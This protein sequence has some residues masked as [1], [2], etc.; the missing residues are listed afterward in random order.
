MWFFV[1]SIV[2]YEH[3]GYIKDYQFYIHKLN[4]FCRLRLLR[5]PPASHRRLPMCSPS[6]SCRCG[7]RCMIIAWPSVF[8]RFRVKHDHEFQILFHHFSLYQRDVTLKFSQIC[9][10]QSESQQQ[11]RRVANHV[12]LKDMWM[13]QNLWWSR[14]HRYT[15]CCGN[16]QNTNTV[17]W[18]LIIGKILMHDQIMTNSWC[19]TLV[20]G[21]RPRAV[22][23]F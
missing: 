5:S 13:F 11:A 17:Y 14:N 7:P 21:C 4:C 19:S 6:R 18:T 20:A 3:N 8:D 15:Q 2:L 23:T 12:L 10:G 16:L 22:Q 1:Q 9:Q